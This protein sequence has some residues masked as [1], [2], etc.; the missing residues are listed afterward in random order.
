MLLWLLYEGDFRPYFTS[1]RIGVRGRAF[2]LL[3]ALPSEVLEPLREEGGPSIF[4]AGPKLDDIIREHFE[5]EMADK[6]LGKSA[7]DFVD[8]EPITWDDMAEPRQVGA[9]FFAWATE[10]DWEEGT[11]RTDLIPARRERDDRLFWDAEEHL[12]SNI[13]DD[14]DFDVFLS[15]LCFELS[16]V[17]MLLPT[18]RIM[19]QLP[20][21]VARGEQ[22]GSLGRPRKWDW[23]A[24]LAH[25]VALANKPDGLPTGHGAQARIEGLLTQWFLD[26][27]GDS[28]AVSQIRARAQKIVRS[29]D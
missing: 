3:N 27:A 8:D 26:Q 22:S 4:Q 5:P 2:D 7:M 19:P 1:G 11:L 24:A 20:L 9:G 6:L 21:L 17:E 16:A 10:I 23:D 14:P 18:E 15:G 13:F 12:S 29:L 28:P 25:I